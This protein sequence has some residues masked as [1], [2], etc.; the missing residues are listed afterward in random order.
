MGLQD[1]IQRGILGALG[2]ALVATGQ[3]AGVLGGL[4]LIAL[5]WRKLG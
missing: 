3:L 2:I 4:V 5:A 1:D